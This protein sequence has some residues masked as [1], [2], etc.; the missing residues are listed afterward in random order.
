MRLQKN[1]I[2]VSVV[3]FC[4]VLALAKLDQKPT[5]QYSAQIQ[6]KQSSAISTS[7]KHQKSK[8]IMAEKQET[9]EIQ[10]ISGGEAN[11]EFSPEEIDG[12]LQSLDLLSRSISID[13]MIS[14]K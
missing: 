3:V 13:L 4:V 1:I 8:S 2:G 9:P 7:T 5:E 11:G 10:S 12:Q 14:E 6:A